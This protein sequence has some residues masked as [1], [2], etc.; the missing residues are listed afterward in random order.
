MD[1]WIVLNE[2]DTIIKIGGQSE[3]HKYKN[4]CDD[5]HPSGKYRLRKLKEGMRIVNAKK[6]HS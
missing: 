3:C 6:Y 4:D 5:K 1:V 2:S